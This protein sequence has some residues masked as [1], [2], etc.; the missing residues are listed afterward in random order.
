MPWVRYL[1]ASAQM[2]N[3]KTKKKPGSA[4]DRQLFLLWMNPQKARE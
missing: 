4:L 2:A 3:E 1:S